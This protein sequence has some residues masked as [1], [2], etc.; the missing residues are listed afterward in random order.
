MTVSVPNGGVEPGG[1][2]SAEGLLAFCRQHGRVCPMPRH[3]TAL[4][5]LLPNRVRV[6]Y[7][8]RPGLPLIL[9]AWHDS[10]ALMKILRLEEQIRWA[11]EH[12]ALDAIARFLRSLDEEDW[13]HFGEPT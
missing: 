8:W 12:G 10:P 1:V 4:W 5:E 13:F 2:E 3:W 7:G 6:G 11:A 9:G